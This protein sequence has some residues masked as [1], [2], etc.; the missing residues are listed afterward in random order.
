MAARPAHCSSTFVSK[1][2]SLNAASFSS[3]KSR[4]ALLFR[5]EKEAAFK[6]IDLE[7]NVEEQW[8]GRAAITYALGRRADSDAAAKRLTELASADWA[9][10]IACVHAYR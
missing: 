10:G 1:S 6:E 4:A 3:R 7:T 9:Y 5:E 2:I 8:A